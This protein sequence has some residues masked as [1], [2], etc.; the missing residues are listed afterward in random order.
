M[1]STNYI[2]LEGKRFLTEFQ[3]VLA[4]IVSA[5]DLFT[6]LTEIMSTSD[7]FLNLT[8]LCPHLIYL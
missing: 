1:I 7:L 5:S 3:Q 6:N 4:E 2:R 8:E